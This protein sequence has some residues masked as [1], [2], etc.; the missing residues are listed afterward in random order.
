M[1]SLIKM[2]IN[3][4]FLLLFLIFR[5]W[6]KHKA[7]G[8]PP[9]W[10]MINAAVCRSYRLRKREYDNGQRDYNVGIIILDN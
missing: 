4:F 9:I 10:L 5:T 2:E 6:Y 7:R 1:Y 3:F 8:V